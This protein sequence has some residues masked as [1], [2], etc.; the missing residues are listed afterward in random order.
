MTTRIEFNVVP[1]TQQL[2]MP[3]FDLSYLPDQLLTCTGVCADW[4][5]ERF[6]EAVEEYMRFVALC[7]KYPRKTIGISPDGDKIWHQHILNTRRYM[8]DSENFF[9]YYFHH[10]PVST[11]EENAAAQQESNRLFLQEF[12]ISR[13]GSH[14]STCVASGCMN[15][16]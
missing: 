7:K 16:G 12:G 13:V 9:G 10:T 15:N 14:M 4:T 1:T 11:E 3:N 2:Q 8:E 5:N 6:I